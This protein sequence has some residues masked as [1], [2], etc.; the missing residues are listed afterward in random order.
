MQVVL[1]GQPE[2]DATLRQAELR[3]LR[4]RIA[5]AYRLDGMCADELGFY[6]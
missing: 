6:V 4:Q 5:F 1:F 3:Q 2:L